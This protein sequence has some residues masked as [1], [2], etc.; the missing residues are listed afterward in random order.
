MKKIILLL[1]IYLT[2]ASCD[3][4]EQE[5]IDAVSTQE[6]FVR[7]SD[8]EAAIVGTYRHLANTGLNYIVFAELPTKNTV[9]NAL[10]RQFEQM[11]NLIFVADNSQFGILWDQQYVL[12]NSANVVIAKVPGIPGMTDAAKNAIVAEARFL[13]AFTYFNLVR[14]FGS[15]PLITNPT[16]SPDVAAL[17]IPR[18]PTDAIYKQILEDLDFAKLN[19]PETH[20]GL[21]RTARATKAA[22]FALGARIHLHRKSWALA[23]ADANQV[24]SRRGE[25][26]TV[27]YANLFLTKNAAESIFE[28]N[29]DTQLQNNLA[30]TFLPASLSGTRTIQINPNLVAAYEAADARKDATIGFANADNYLKKYSRGGTKDDNII[31]LRLAE[32]L[33]AKAEALAETSYPSADA[34]KLLNEV[35]RRAGLGAISPVDIAAFRTALYKERR[36]E[37]SFEGHEWFDIVRTGRL[38]QVLGITDVNKSI[39]PVPSA[40]IARNPKLLPQNPGY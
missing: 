33:L 37:L 26:L 16:E 22:A 20:A 8:A 39:W 27:A 29:Y 19:L 28:I 24:I 5:P 1:C 25:A 11:N 12:V 3:V 32:V 23:I 9:G 34:L 38:Q 15:V 21:G 35:R 14:Y 2:V 30:T 17:Q 18:T 13:R 40:E 10:N 6:L 7:P 4:T 31:V 36:L